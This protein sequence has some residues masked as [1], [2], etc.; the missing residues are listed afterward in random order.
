MNLAYEPGKFTSFAQ[1]RRMAKLLDRMP[2]EKAEKLIEK[3]KLKV[4]K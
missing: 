2:R 4:L 1:Y 3:Y